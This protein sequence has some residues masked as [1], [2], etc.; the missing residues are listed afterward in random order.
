MSEHYNEKQT[1]ELQ[2]GQSKDEQI[3]DLL[4][5][6]DILLNANKDLKERYEPIIE[7]NKDVHALEEENKVL[8][9]QIRIRDNII[10][11]LVTIM[12]LTQKK[13]IEQGALETLDLSLNTEYDLILK[14]VELTKTVKRLE[15]SNADLYDS[16]IHNALC[17]YSLSGDVDNEKKYFELL[18]PIGKA[19]YMQ[20]GKCPLN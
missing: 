3:N 15:D 20:S 19:R 11:K 4:N 16:A 8:T 14:V 9:T 6:V 7:K 17:F 2:Q 18:S 5:Q 1:I 12:N 13:S 10:K